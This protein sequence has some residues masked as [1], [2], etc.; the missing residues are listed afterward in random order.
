MTPDAKDQFR[1]LT[2]L[3]LAVVAV[4]LYMVAWLLPMWGWYL[5]APQ[6]PQG[7]VLSVYMNHVQG[8]I[9]EINILNHYIGMAKLDEAAQLERAMALY[10]VC[11]IGLVTMLAVFFPGKRYAHYFALPAFAFPFV[12]VSL[13]FFWMYRFGHELSPD[14]PVRVAAFTPTLVGHG[15]IGNFHTLGLPGAGFYAILGSA[16][17]VALAFALR[18]KVC[19]GC[20][21]GHDC[22][23]FCPTL[24]VRRP[25]RLPI[26]P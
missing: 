17:A 12:F 15:Q 5:H 2:V 14:A 25:S 8:D 7:L 24:F 20:S 18:R 16:V 19:G 6:Y 22:G 23:T 13:M 1:R 21:K 26:L 3:G 11:G 9:S 10:G 4:G